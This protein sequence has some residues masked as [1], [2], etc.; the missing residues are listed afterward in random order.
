VN[1]LSGPITPDGCLV[2][3]L[4]GLAAGN[5]R[6]RRQAGQPIP[7]PVAVRALLDTGAQ[8]SCADP[9]ALAP[10]I[11]LG[12][13][14][15]RLI[16]TNVPA[17]GGISVGSEYAAG[18]TIVH[19]SG[20]ARANLVLR[21]WPVVEVPLGPLGYQALIGRDVLSRCLFIQDGPGNTFLLAY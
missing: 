4:I 3:L 12:L 20:D 1:T 9:Q 19:P 14:R 10:L 15:T 7:P 21:H 2:D 11:A 18:L 8:A 6:Q 17:L 5:V 13:H 16:L